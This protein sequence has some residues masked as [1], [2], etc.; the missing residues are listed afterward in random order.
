MHVCLIKIV[1]KRKLEKKRVKEKI[2]FAL[3]LAD[4]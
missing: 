3:C 1:K 4:A 2:K